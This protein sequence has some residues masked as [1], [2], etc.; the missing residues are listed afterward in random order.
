MRPMI[1]ERTLYYAKPGL[2]DEVLAIRR[3]AGAI[4]VAIGLP[5]GEIFARVG[6]AEA[7]EPDVIWECAFLDRAAQEADLAARGASAD[8][9]AIR[10]E[11]S[12]RLARF[13]RHVLERDRAGLANGVRSLELDDHPILPREI[14]FRSGAH[15]LKGYLHLPPGPGPFPC[16]ITNH[17]STIQKGTLDVSRP[18]TAALLMSWGIVSFLPHRHGYG[19]SPG[20]A[21]RDE[22][23]AE[24]GT[25]DYDWQVTARLDRESDDVIAA[26]DCVSALPEI[27]ADHIGVMGSS[28][29]GINT[30]LAAAKTD[31]FRCA[32]EFAGA[33]MNWDRAPGLRE[34]LTKAA[35]RVTAPIFFIQA[36]NDF[37]IRPTRELA[38]A[39]EG[40]GKIVWSKIYPAFGINPEEGHLLESR[41]H[42]LWGNDVRVFLEQYL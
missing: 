6:A 15:Q 2:A 29:G 36:A 10:A 28:F 1:V 35:R 27:R 39:L 17:G 32:V 40:T 13:S 3:R 26:L 31:R 21:W 34:H 25:P 11:V 4:R 23:S 16:M 7:E 19:N 38:G 18:G 20:P 12:A 37:S 30:L 24:F 22:A 41:G 8:F 42:T 33:A 9:T 5:A 14:T